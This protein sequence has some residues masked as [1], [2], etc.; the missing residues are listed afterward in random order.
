MFLCNA[1]RANI[2]KAKSC[3]TNLIAFYKVTGSMDKGDQNILLIVGFSN[4]F[5]TVSCNN[6]ADKLLKFRSDKWT[7]NGLPENCLNCQT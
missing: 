5:D 2:M 4:A 6:H 1:V 7:V 3:L